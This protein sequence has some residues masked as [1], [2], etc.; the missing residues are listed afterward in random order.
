MGE[1]EALM[2]TV[3]AAA[4]DDDGHR[5]TTRASDLSRQTVD[6]LFR[7]HYQTFDTALFEQ[8]DKIGDRIDSEVPVVAQIPRGAVGGADLAHGKWRFPGLVPFG[9]GQAENREVR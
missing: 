2:L 3:D 7:V 4:D 5:L 8:F 9:A 6:I 1:I